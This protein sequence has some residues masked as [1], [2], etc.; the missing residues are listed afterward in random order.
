MVIIYESPLREGEYTVHGFSIDAQSP[1]GHCPDHPD[2]IVNAFETETL[3]EDP[4]L[5]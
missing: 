4:D 5:N 2:A 3:K 1:Q